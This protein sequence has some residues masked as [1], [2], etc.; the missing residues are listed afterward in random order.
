M[1][2]L[3]SVEATSEAKPVALKN[4]DQLNGAENMTCMAV[5]AEDFLAPGSFV[6]VVHKTNIPLVSPTKH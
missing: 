1:I 3:F 2:L 4:L 5:Y 6:I